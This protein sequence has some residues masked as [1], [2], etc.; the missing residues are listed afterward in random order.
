MRFYLLAIICFLMASASAQHRIKHFI[1]FG[2]DRESIQDTDFLNEKNITGAQ[3]RYAWKDLEPRKDV[4]DFSMIAQDMNFLAKHGK[5]LFVQIT[6]ATFDSTKIA[7]PGY[8]LE[9][10]I[11]NGGANVQ[12]HFSDEDETLITSKAGWTARRWDPEVRKRFQKLLIVLGEAFD[13]KIEGINLQE[14]S[15]GFGKGALHPKGFSYAAYRDG[16]LDNMKAL[17]AAFQRSVVI[18][19]ANFMPGEFMPWKDSG[20]L[21]SVY[22]F[23]RH[24][25]IGVGGPDILV[26]KKGQ[27]NNSYP[28]IR[29]SADF[30]TTG[31]AV[32]DGNYSLVNPKTGRQV[33]VPEIYAFAKDYLR[34]HYIFWCDEEPYYKREVL[35]FLLNLNKL[36]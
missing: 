3:L 2:A 17:R 21:R 9:D 18:Q 35:P 8:L 30:V 29:E 10:P 31:V 26:Y 27:M 1:Y 36:H 25:G 14:T 6:D 15:I 20:Y 5:K 34:L 7:V 4:Y 16:V 23:A 13:G 12:Y 11:Y 32:Q 24:H 28:L 33:T 22:D 19:Y